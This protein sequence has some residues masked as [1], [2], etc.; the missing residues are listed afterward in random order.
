MRIV[1]TYVVIPWVFNHG[2]QEGYLKRNCKCGGIGKT[3]SIQKMS[4][5]SFIEIPPFCQI[6]R[7]VEGHFHHP[8]GRPWVTI[9]DEA[10]KLMA[11]IVGT[12][13]GSFFA[14]NR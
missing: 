4:F 1:F 12:V 2:T 8:F 3:V 13:N 14:D 5:D 9:A 10:A 11:N 6:S 7:G